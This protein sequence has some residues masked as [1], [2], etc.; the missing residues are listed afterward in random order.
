MLI[1]Y[2]RM[3]NSPLTAAEL[4]WEKAFKRVYKLL[5]NY[6]IEYR[7]KPITLSRAPPDI[8]DLITKIKTNFILSDQIIKTCFISG[9]DAYNFYIR[10]AIGDKN[11]DQPARITFKTDRLRSMLV[12]PPILDLISVKYIECVEA[13][14]AFL[15]ARVA[16]PGLLSLDEYFPLF[17]FTNRSVTFNY[18]E[19][20][21]VRIFEAD[22]HCVPFIETTARY[23]YV[24]FQYLFMVFLIGKFRAHLDKNKEMYFNYDIA[25][26]NL[27]NARN[28]F[29]NKKSEQMKEKVSVI[30][31]SPFGEFKVRCVGTTVSYQR[32]S[33]LRGLEKRKQGKQIRFVYNPE[34]FRNK[35]PEDQAKFDPK[36]WDKRY[37]NTSGNKITNP[38][39]LFFKIDENFDLTRNVSQVI[40]EDD[41][42]KKEEIETETETESESN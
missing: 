28:I 34:A 40:P 32:E 12:N 7:N 11:N 1:D 25:I 29:L 8:S 18:N 17:Q 31:P 38:K 20:P 6:P 19:V 39:N 23:M 15:K 5:K 2:L 4:R 10:H 30:N 26:S 36:S 14:W 22:G 41:R 35:I 21:I 33:L 16:D 42:I 37:K 27:V 13:M 3:I 9:F 24:T